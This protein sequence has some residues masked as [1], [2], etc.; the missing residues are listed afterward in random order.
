MLSK[1]KLKCM[2]LGSD[3]TM[4]FWCLI[5]AKSQPKN[6]SQIAYYWVD[7][8]WDWQRKLSNTNNIKDSEYIIIWHTITWWRLCYLQST[9]NSTDT[10]TRYRLKDYFELQ[11]S[12]YDKTILER[13]DDFCE[14]ILLPFLKSIEW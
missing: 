5:S 10:S 7:S 1:I 8:N 14:N 11:N 2:E 13:P 6:I 12:L 3:K 9:Y 4:S